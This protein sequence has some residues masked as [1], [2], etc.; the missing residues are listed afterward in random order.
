M[1]SKENKNEIPTDSLEGYY[2]EQ[3]DMTAFE[4]QTERTNDYMFGSEFQP[5]Y[6]EGSLAYFNKK[7]HETLQKRAQQTFY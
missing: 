7:T 4:K 2:E 5:T 6:P 3:A 1:M